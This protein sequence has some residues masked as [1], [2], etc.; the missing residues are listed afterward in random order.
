MIHEMKGKQVW[1]NRELIDFK[2][3]VC[4]RRVRFNSRTR[5]HHVMRC[6]DQIFPHGARL[7]GILMMDY[8]RVKQLDVEAD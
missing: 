2:C 7:K 8:P 5:K 1:W 3:L 4:K 6:G